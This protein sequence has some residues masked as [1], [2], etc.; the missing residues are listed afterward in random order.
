MKEND[1]QYKEENQSKPYLLIMHDANHQ[2]DDRLAPQRAKQHA[3]YQQHK[4]ENNVNWG[5][6]VKSGCFPKKSMPEKFI[7]KLFLEL[8]FALQWCLRIMMQWLSLNLDFSFP[9]LPLNAI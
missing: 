8:I 3:G 6:K 4:M 9:T 1:V 7:L 2:A 5:S